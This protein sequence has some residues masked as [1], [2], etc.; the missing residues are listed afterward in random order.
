MNLY[1]FDPDHAR[2]Q[3]AQLRRPARLPLGSPAVTQA[4]AEL[5]VGDIFR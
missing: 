4:L 5:H 3:A 1:Q 2:A